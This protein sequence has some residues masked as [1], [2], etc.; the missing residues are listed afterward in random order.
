[1]TAINNYII[2]FRMKQIYLKFLMLLLCLV[3]G[4]SGWA[5]DVTGTITF[6]NNNVKISSAS[7][8][9]KD[10]QDNTWTI[11][12]VGTTSFTQSADYSQVGSS[13]KPATSITFTTTLPALQNIKNVTAKFSG[14]NG[15]VGNVD[16]KVGDTTVGS[17]KLNAAN[18]VIVSSTSEADGKKITVT[19]SGIEKG[20]V[21]YYISYT[22]GSVDGR[23][24]VNMTSFTTADN[25]TSIVKGRTLAT[26]VA[27][28]QSG[29]NSAYTY[30]SSNEDVA[31]V[32]ND[33]TITAVAKGAAT[34]TASL[35]VASNDANYKAGAT[36]TKTINITV[37]NPLHKVRFSANG[38]IVSSAD[39][40][41]GESITFPSDKPADIDNNIFMGWYGE[42][43]SN[44]TVAPTYVTSGTMGEKDITY[45]AVY[46]TRSGSEA[47]ETLSQTL[48]YDTWTYGGS[49]T[50]KSTYRLFHTNGY[51][52]SDEFD[53]SR[54]SKVVVYGGTFGGTSYKNLTIGDGTNTWK[55]VTVSGSSATGS[56]TYTGGTSLNGT[57]K[58]RITSGSGSSSSG[59]GVRISKVEIY[60][61]EGGYTYSDFRTSIV[62][63][64]VSSISVKAVPSKVVYTEGETLDLTGLVLTVNYTEGEPDEISSGY[65]S[66]PA[67]GAELTTIGEN[68]ITITYKEKT[69]SFN[70]TV[71]AI[72]TYTAKFSVNGTIDETTTFVAQEGTAVSFPVNPSIEG[73][74]FVGWTKTAVD[75]VSETAPSYVKPAN[76]KVGTADVTYYA[77]FATQ[78]GDSGE[79]WKRV[80][81]VDEITEG[82]YIIK[83]DAYVISN[84][85]TTNSPVSI[86]APDVEDG[87]LD[88][89]KV[90]GSMKWTFVATNNANEFQ[91]QR[92]ND[93]SYYLYTSNNNDGVN[94]SNTQSYSWTFSKNAKAVSGGDFSMK[95]NTYSRYL[96]LQTTNNSPRWISNTTATSGNF[97][98][99]GIIE[100]YKLHTA[101]Y[102]DFWT[103][104][105]TPYTAKSLTFVAYEEG[106]S[107]RYY[108]ATFS[109]DKVT[110]FPSENGLTVYTVN[111]EGESTL[112]LDALEEGTL[113]VDDQDV[114]GTYVPANTG[115][116]ISESY[117]P[118]GN[119]TITYYTVN[120]KTISAI[121][122][123]NLLRPASAAMT[124]DY[125]FYKLAY[126]DYTNKTGLGFYYGAENGGAFTCK[127]GTAYLSV[128]ASQAVKSF[129]LSGA[130]TDITNVE[131]ATKSVIYNLN[132]QRLNKMQKGI[133]IVDG[134]KYFVK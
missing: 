83:S 51:V 90:T 129:T 72:P 123:T 3:V 54:L 121:E 115:V 126:D 80:E 46:S 9:G 27:N 68:T 67:N 69:T 122:G 25:V 105:P 14:F 107:D 116:L 95:Q 11:T 127:A 23:T 77:V 47:V 45:Y 89:T 130:A 26:S 44:E 60:T 134:K 104:E 100:L 57:G 1:M 35:N 2:Y 39:V 55:S 50:D 32:A 19:V 76:E 58:L 62:Q 91:I 133:N 40:E 42:V 8:T 21:C 13:S 36:R 22:Y 102:S 63:R 34:I 6:G 38:D 75:G 53:L 79:T 56:N 17:G 16:I 20:V 10:T 111:V 118:E 87:V 117:F 106:S 48:E 52:E 49:T 37:T 61:L 18:N 78:T 33:G 28:D 41:E 84:A 128:P 109:S 29:W 114:S 86:A 93:A 82:T 31:T 74:T 81:S 71:N 97:R 108:Y 59:T 98:N 124:G 85:R 66:N 99:N 119:L 125:K 103:T 96:G 4:L 5:E 65:S 110:F 24:A 30:S 94:V 15:T 132:G 112:K 131:T 120:N 101:T 88:A 64:E 7:V 113:N 73:Y 92:Y 70:V 43:Y 12:T